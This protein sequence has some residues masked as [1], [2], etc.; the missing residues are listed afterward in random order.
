MYHVHRCC[1]LIVS[2]LCLL[3][4]IAG[5]SS[6]ADS[7]SKTLSAPLPVVTTPVVEQ[8]SS[9]TFTL[10]GG[11]HVSDTIDA[12][13]PTS[14]LRHGHREFTIDVANAD[15]SLFIVFYGYQ[16]PGRYTLS[17]YLNGGDIHIGLAQAGPS[18]DL[19]LQTHASCSLTVASDTP[20]KNVG[21][22]HME[23]T[24]SCPQLFSSAPDHPE[25][26]I[27][28]DRGTFDVTIVVES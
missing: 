23:G 13:I 18:W 5:C 8:G 19:S 22:D 28:V 1:R 7:A 9:A 16:G 17:Q 4:I 26:T 25:P 11:Y 6:P 10:S 24:F 2:S 12:T 27:R 14:K 15:Q 20:T 21:L 3:L